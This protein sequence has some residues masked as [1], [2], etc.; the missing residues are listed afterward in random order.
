MFVQ[1]IRQNPLFGSPYFI[2]YME[3]LRTGEGIIDLLNVYFAIGMAY[4]L[5]TLAAFISFFAVAAFRCVRATR[6]ITRMDPDTAKLGAALFASLSAT[7][8]IMYTVSNYLSVP[9]ICVGLAALMVA[10]TRVALTD[11]LTG[12]G[13]GSDAAGMRGPP[14]VRVSLS[15]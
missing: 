10:Y 1:L 8:V 15:G 6:A 4:G 9:Y 2:E 3:D 7:M 12:S 13:D 14:G 5:V 11:E